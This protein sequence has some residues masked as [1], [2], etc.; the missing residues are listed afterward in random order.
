MTSRQIYYSVHGAP[1]PRRSPRAPRG[2]GPARSW[3]YRAWI[4]TLPCAACGHN[5]DIEAAHTGSDG[6]KAQKSSDYSCVPRESAA[7]D[8]GRPLIVTLHPRHL[9][10]RPKG[11]RRRYTISYEACLW[12]AVKR[13]LDEQR[14]EKAAARKRRRG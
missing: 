12:L 14:R 2:R 1:A 6:G 9:E 8:R 5:R 10:V 7:F 13:E 11:T 4:R 3:R